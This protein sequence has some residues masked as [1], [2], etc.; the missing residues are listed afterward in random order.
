VVLDE[1][2][3]LKHRSAARCDEATTVQR[4]QLRD[5]FGRASDDQLRELSGALAIALDI[6]AADIADL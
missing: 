4:T 2:N 3:G 1:R 6:S 5:S